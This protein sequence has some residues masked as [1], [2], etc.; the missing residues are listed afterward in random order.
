MPAQAIAVS[1][2][3]S[4]AFVSVA[5]GPRDEGGAAAAGGGGA[6]YG[7]RLEHGANGIAAAQHLNGLRS[8][9]ARWFGPGTQQT[10]VD[11]SLVG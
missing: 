6:V 3:G 4:T 8:P 7:F 1:G 2:D 9:D 10:A 5:N 11:R